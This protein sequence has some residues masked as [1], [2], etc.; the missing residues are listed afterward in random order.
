MIVCQV[1]GYQNEDDDTFCGGCP[2]YLPH[3]GVHVDDDQPVVV[4]E[5]EVAP[6]Q[7]GGLIQRVKEMVG[8][9]DAAQPTTQAGG[10]LLEA[11]P[12]TAEVTEANAAAQQ[13]EAEARAREEEAQQRR[14][15][16]RRAE[17]EAAAA[18]AARRQAREEAEAAAKAREEAERQARQEA[19]ARAK[20][21]AEEREAQA[22]AERE[23]AA[24]LARE[25]QEADE[26]AAAEARA[27]AEAEA[28]AAAEDEAAERARLEAEVLA[29]REAEERAR[30][31]AEEQAQ[32]EAEA[33]RRAEA[34]E[35]ERAEAQRREE[36][37]AKRRAAEEAEA[38]RK[39]E[40][41]ARRRA[42]EEERALR[43]AEQR[44]AQ[45]RLARE[46]AEREAAEAAERARRAAAMVAKPPPAKPKAGGKTLPSAAGAG[47][48]AVQDGPAAVAG[49]QA[50]T[51]MK[52]AVSRTPPPRPTS[53]TAPTRKAEPG[54]L[55]CGQCGE[56][57]KPDRKFCRRCAND[58][59]EAQ[60][61]K[62]KWWHVFKR[63]KK[64]VA[65]GERPGHTGRAG[66]KTSKGRGAAK[67]ARAVVRWTMALVLIAIV[68]LGVLGSLG[69]GPGRT[70]LRDGL[71]GLTQRVR[72]IVSPSYEPAN[73]KS[74]SASAAA[75]GHP[76]DDAVD[77]FDNT[78]W[79]AGV[80][81]AQQ[82]SLT[83]NFP[84]PVD[85]ARVLIHSGA[86]GD[87]FRAQARPRRI[88]LVYSDGS[89][90]E[91]DLKDVPEVQEFTI[92]ATRARRARLVVL[93]VHPGSRTD[94]PAITELEFFTKR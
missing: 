24:R 47:A 20:A 7:G 4:E 18:A 78:H 40:E 72:D 49:A 34:A 17:E 68:V 80:P 26:R 60:V 9:D 77:G 92:S 31:E 37:D 11:S 39:E 70:F 19:E 14:E 8:A 84:R 90:D 12:A 66:G 74:V 29:R 42:E 3:S 25:K 28:A 45:E 2:A 91:L 53:K 21:E 89:R 35:R 62:R 76:A 93:S 15:A 48:A 94:A 5:A 59:N 82:P 85:L 69:I 67:G 13:A 23:E 86:S 38:K 10:V 32:A 27:L 88:R 1:C 61:A 83:M 43:E 36:E 73:P 50:P 87:A 51:A 6:T 55:I 63:S 64:V 65:A 79:S 54:D 75:N 44:A 56:P 46:K 52:P 58:L 71:S 33:Q 41:E 57:N 16:E 30:Q 22:E 81:V